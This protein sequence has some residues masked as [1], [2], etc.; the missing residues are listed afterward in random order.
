M[1]EEQYRE[2]AVFLEQ[3]VNIISQTGVK[4]VSL[5]KRYARIMLPFEPNINH[6]GTIY[7]GSLF[8][9]AEFSGG[10]IYYVSFDHTKFY[11]IVKEVF[12]QYRRPATG[13]VY[14]DVELSSEQVDGIQNSAES[15]G[16]QDWTME[17]E[18]KDE[19]GQVCCSVRGTWQLRRF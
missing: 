11:P 8:I 10:V 3:A 2:G 12:I 5:K 6:I 4:I 16:K 17:L 19:S 7:G 15:H 13:D 9:L 1:I 18:I 14:L